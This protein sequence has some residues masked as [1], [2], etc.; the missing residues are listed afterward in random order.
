MQFLIRAKSNFNVNT[1]N[2]NKHKSVE[3]ESNLLKSGKTFKEEETD[4][5][6]NLNSKNKIESKE[7]NHFGCR[8]HP[9][10]K[11][12]ILKKPEEKKTINFNLVF[13]S[14]I[15]KKFFEDDVNF[16]NHY[17]MI[18]KNR[19]KNKRG[20]REYNNS[21]F[22]KQ[23][24]EDSMANEVKESGNETEKEFTILKRKDS[25]KYNKKLLLTQLRKK[26]KKT[27]SRNMPRHSLSDFK[28]RINL[29]FFNY[30]LMKIM[31]EED[32]NKNLIETYNLKKDEKSSYHTNT[33]NL[34]CSQQEIFSLNS[35][36]RIAQEYKKRNSLYNKNPKNS[37][38]NH[39][40][41]LLSFPLHV[42][43]GSNQVVSKTRNFDYGMIYSQD[44]S[45]LKNNNL[46]SNEVLK[47]KINKITPQLNQVK[48][49]NYN[50]GKLLNI[51]YIT[52]NNLK[53]NESKFNSP[54]STCFRKN[55]QSEMKLKNTISSQKKMQT[56][57]QNSFREINSLDKNKSKFQLTES[58]SKF[59]KKTTN[60]EK[61]CSIVSDSISNNMGK[62][63][64]KTLS[65][66]ENINELKNRRGTVFQFGNNSKIDNEFFDHVNEP[67]RKKS[68]LN[69]EKIE[70]NLKKR[71]KHDEEKVKKIKKQKTLF[72]EE[73]FKKNDTQT[74]N[75]NNN[76]LEEYLKSLFKT[77]EV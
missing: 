22:F 26:S 10:K 49:S 21:Q 45:G 55:F 40:P 50:K 39:F 59:K 27:K 70:T 2:L 13:S 15:V 20:G 5:V 30:M 4:R 61:T 29:E 42:K 58:L 76:G 17:S 6:L 69:S 66:I 9:K 65:K 16:T 41:M 3:L 8:T 18:Y 77:K 53:R 7:I 32:E 73:L 38:N 19:E 36:K 47:A 68:L 60:I 71:K 12:L 62:K 48:I 56:K 52:Q 44:E 28:S 54:N 72:I 33:S 51:N 46:I 67:P 64:T 63:L 14:L 34:I 11:K 37:K 74:S 57:K 23:E 43:K 35:N 1:N 75:T 24:I 25:K 31:H